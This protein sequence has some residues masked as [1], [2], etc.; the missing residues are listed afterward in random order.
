MNEQLFS[1]V[2]YDY[3]KAMENYTKRFVEHLLE[4][5]SGF[6]V[7]ILKGIC[8]NISC[9]IDS[10]LASTGS[11]VKTLLQYLICAKFFSSSVGH[12]L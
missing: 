12:V 9:I 1:I 7:V 8:G 5:A 4:I 3:A 10:G 11:V 2:F 6:V